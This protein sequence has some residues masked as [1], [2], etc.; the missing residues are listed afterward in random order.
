VTVRELDESILWISVAYW[1]LISV[2]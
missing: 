1:K 2:Y